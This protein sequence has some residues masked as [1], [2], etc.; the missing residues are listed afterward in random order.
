LSYAARRDTATG[1]TAPVPAD[2]A[3]CHYFKT[4]LDG[5]SLGTDGYFPKAA[6]DSIQ[7]SISDLQSV[8]IQKN[9]VIGFR[10]Q[11]GRKG[12]IRV[13]DVNWFGAVLNIWIE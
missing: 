8:P 4:N 7:V 13:E 11:D 5:Q 1:L 3:T 12:I 9:D 6:F 10:N 2:A